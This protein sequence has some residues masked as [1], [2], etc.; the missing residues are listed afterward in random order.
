M[1]KKRLDKNSFITIDDAI[2]K[3]CECNLACF[4]CLEQT[5]VVYTIVR[6]MKQWTLDRIDN[7][8]GHISSNV[9]ISCL[10]CNLKRRRIQQ[11]AFLFTKQLNIVKI[12]E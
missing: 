2:T 3:L 8:I 11:D 9:V 7:N 4:Y 1:L 10:D 6:E 12:D 5:M